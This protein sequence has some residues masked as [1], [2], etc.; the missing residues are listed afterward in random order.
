M[1]EKI[2]TAVMYRKCGMPGETFF[3]YLVGPM[4]FVYVS[5]IGESGTEPV[6]PGCPLWP[7]QTDAE[8]LGS[9]KRLAK[10][11]LGLE[12]NDQEAVPANPFGHPFFTEPM[13]KTLKMKEVR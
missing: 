9:A 12:S 13:S 10:K 5:H 7:N 11:W 6:D 1:L 2:D 4:G 8:G 3:V